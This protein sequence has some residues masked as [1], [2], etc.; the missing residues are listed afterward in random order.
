MQSLENKIREFGNVLS[1]TVLKVDSFLNHQ[2]DAALM[3]EVGKEFAERFKDVQATK[4]LTLESSGIAPSAMLGLVLGLPVIFARKRKSLTLS[5]NLLSAT[6]HSFTKN[7]TS[8]IS[9]S[10]DF[11]KEGDQV[12]IID[13]FL[14]NGE[15]V[16]GL[17]SVVEQAGA[18]TVGVGIVIEKG[19]QQGGK[20]L[21]EKGVR[22]ES[23]AIV[24]S[25]DTDHI[26]F[27][28]Q[29]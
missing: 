2:I 29:N 9:V 4:I 23:L 13:D 28:Q 17:L 16:R 21:R 26:T 25:M 19:F 11:L 18:T 3:M 6:V 24:D 27:R 12:I 20:E 1:P 15:A 22:L 10:R 5:D 8:E 14:A 7:V